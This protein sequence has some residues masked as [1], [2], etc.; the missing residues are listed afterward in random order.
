MKSPKSKSILLL[1]VFVLTC[2]HIV[3]H[4]QK[5][6]PE[7]KLGAYFFAGWCGK[8]ASDDGKPENKWAVGM[9]SHVTKKLL[10]DFSG[11]TPVWGWRDDTMKL[12]NRQINLAADNGISYFSFCWYWADNKVSIN[13]DIIKSDSK[14]LPIYMF[15]DAK[16]NKR[17][18]FSLMIAN[19]EGFEIKGT[20]AWMQATD[21]WIENYFK[22]PRYLKVDGKPVITIFLPEGAD[23][24]GLDYL[25]K[26]AKKSGFPGVYVIGCGNCLAANGFQAQ[27]QYNTKP[28]SGLNLTDI[29]PFR[30]LSDWNIKTW[31][32]SNPLNMAY[33]P[34]V[35]AGWDRRPWEDIVGVPVSVHFDR[36]TP[37]EFEFYVRSLKKW[38]ELNPNKLTNNRLA[39]VYAWNEI[40]EGG[41]LVPCKDDP[42]GK[43]LKAIKKAIL[44]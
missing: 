39:I 17:M 15:M 26:A 20:E 7:M 29:Y 41:W 14:H 23:K 1:L 31:E 36:G 30:L 43:Y 33:V 24:S 37:Q 8:C 32:Q 10:D 16:C 12:M 35:T 28:K 18:E 44:K 19:H 42:Q 6:Q 5:Q 38:M 21:F 25:Q 11:R 4:A 3:L 22:H 2:G 40:A 34:C 9:P 13:S 27:T